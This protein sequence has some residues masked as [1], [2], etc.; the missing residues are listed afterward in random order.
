MHVGQAKRY[1]PLPD[2]DL[3]DPGV[4]RGVIHG[5]IVDPAYTRLLLQNTGLSLTEVLA[6]DRVQKKLPIPDSMIN[7]LRKAC[8]LEGRKPL[9]HITA[10]IAKATD[11]KADYI[12]TRK[13]ADVFYMKLVVDYVRQYGSATRKDIDN[14]LFDKLSRVLSDEQKHNK[15]HN[16]LGK[17]KRKKMIKNQGSRSDSLWALI[18]EDKLTTESFD[19]SKKNYYRK[20]RLDYF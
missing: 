20:I 9:L 5:K 15:I 2:Y 7:S 17:M 6:L 19:L 11:T 1:F 10:G 12:R 3:T 16:L 14:L 18:N 13:Q 4:V 8:F